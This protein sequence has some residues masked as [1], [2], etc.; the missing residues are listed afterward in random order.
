[1]RHDFYRTAS[2]HYLRGGLD[3][4]GKLVAYANHTIGFNN[5]LGER[6][7]GEFTD[8]EFPLQVVDHVRCERTSMLLHTPTGSLRAPH[9]NGLGFVNQC[10]IDELAHA[11]GADPLEFRRGL[12]G[13]RRMLPIP[14]SGPYDFGGRIAAIPEMDTGRMRD[15]LDLVAEKSR[16][17]R[18]ELPRRTGLGIAFYYCHYAY[19]AVVARVHVADDGIPSAEKLWVAVDIGAHIVNP[20]RAEQVAAGG[21]LEGMAHVLGPRQKITIEGGRVVQSN[22]HEYTPLRMSQTPEVE[23]HF[24]RTDNPTT[25]LGEPTLPPTPPAVCNAIFAA[26]GVRVRSLPVD[27]A[28]L[29]V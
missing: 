6:A 15:V 11:A 18:S 28:S 1:M 12:L 3:A 19:V 9:S 7:W 23:V 2:F 20:S 13:E 4:A 5:S 17:G 26:T 14:P 21:A 29:A 22:F 24:L 10:F 16:F 8:R 25:G 27:P